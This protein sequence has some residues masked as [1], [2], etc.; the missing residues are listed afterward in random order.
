MRSEKKTVI[1]DAQ[2]TEFDYDTPSKSKLIVSNMNSSEAYL[3]YPGASKFQGERGSKSFTNAEF[4]IYP[5]KDQ[6]IGLAK[7]KFAW[8]II[9]I[10]WN[11][12]RGTQN[13]SFQDRNFNPGATVLFGDSNYAY[14]LIPGKVVRGKGVKFVMPSA[15]NPSGIQLLPGTTIE[16]AK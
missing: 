3:A 13:V 15:A 1:L 9:G 12:P 5:T 4:T 8:A 16:A 7:G 11:K 14:P 10:D 6:S 2:R